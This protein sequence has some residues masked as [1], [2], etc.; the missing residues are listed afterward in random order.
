MRT[1]TQRPPAVAYVVVTTTGNVWGIWT[2][3]F[4]LSQ[5]EGW[6][7]GHVADGEWQVLP[8]TRVPRLER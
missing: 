8:F 3:R 5:A 4:A 2:G 1:R 6:A 7:R